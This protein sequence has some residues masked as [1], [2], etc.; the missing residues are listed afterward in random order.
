MTRVLVLL[1]W[2]RPMTI[3]YDVSER[4]GREPGLDVTV[5]CYEDASLEDV[6]APVDTDAIS[7]EFLG[8][9][10]RFDPDAIGGLRR[11]LASGRFDLLHTQ[12]NFT[13]ALGRAL[14]PRDLLIV[15]TEH[16]DHRLHY[17]AAQ[18]AVNAT[19][20]WRSDRVV[21]NSQAT[22]DSF[23]PHER[24]LVPER[25]R[26]VIYN[27]IDIDAIDELRSGPNPWET[28]RPRVAT[29]GRMIPT[30]NQRALVA[31]FDSVRRSVA[32]AE[33]VVVGDGPERER[34][35]RLVRAYRLG[36]HVT[37]TGTLSRRDVY[38]ILHASDLFALSSRSEGFCVALAEAMAC[39][40]APVVSDIPALHEVAG[41]TA[42]FRDPERTE[43]F[44]DAI[45]RLLRDPDERE[46]RAT[47]AEERARTLF[48]IE[49]SV[50]EYRALY[51]ELVAERA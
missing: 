48:P 12:T 33:L 18:N 44:A 5:A 37:F 9:E 30:K 23:Y 51:E 13:G 16:A 24:L 31:A 6:E 34:L 28:D 11:L 7:L 10:S 17:T 19:T 41:E 50:E 20:L 46:R 22:L 39:G 38:R 15:D 40:L 36:E 43:A 2:I 27:G 8:A 25:K 35:E 32:D 4:L 45:R 14:A 49:R 42:V 47:A 26:R 21:A 29:V 1:N 3:E